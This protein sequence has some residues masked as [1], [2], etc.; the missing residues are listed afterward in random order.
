MTKLNHDDVVSA[1]CGATAD[2]FSTMLGLELTPEAARSENGSA[3]PLD[4]VVALIGLAGDWVGTAMIY[5]SA[6]FACRL[7]TQLL[8]TEAPSVNEEVLDAVGEVTNMIIGNVKTV[9][10]EVVGPLGLSVPTVVFG[11]NFTTRNPGTSTWTVVPFRCEAETMTIKIHLAPAA[12]PTHLRA[13]HT[14]AV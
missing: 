3:T 2:V 7:C 5:C 10:E 12:E 11:H 8:M 13:G 6:E 1:I 9:I 14:V 4:G